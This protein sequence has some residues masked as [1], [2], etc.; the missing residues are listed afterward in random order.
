MHETMVLGLAHARPG[1]L[2]FP[3]ILAR[4]VEAQEDDDA[5][6]HAVAAHVRG[7]GDEV[8]RRVPREK[9]LR[10]WFF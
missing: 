5:D 1:Q 10:T 6:E 8:A 9:D 3:L 7:E 2:V 4:E